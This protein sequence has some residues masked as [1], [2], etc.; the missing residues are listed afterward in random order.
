LVL[1]AQRRTLVELATL[2]VPRAVAN[3]PSALTSPDESSATASNTG[4]ATEHLPI[5]R[6]DVNSTVS[7]VLRSEINDL[8]IKRTE[9]H[10][11]HRS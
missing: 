2:N 11:T 6:P 4:Q 9:V 3:A 1:L 10:S 8:R 5:G 7:R